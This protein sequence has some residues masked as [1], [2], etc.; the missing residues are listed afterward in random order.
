MWKSVKK[1][2]RDITRSRLCHLQLRKGF[3]FVGPLSTV[4]FGT[5]KKNTSE[6]FVELGSIAFSP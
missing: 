6:K 2:T 5:L 4:A 1:G 3:F